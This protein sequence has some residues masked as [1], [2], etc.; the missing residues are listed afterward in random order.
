MNVANLADSEL[1]PADNQPL[2]SGGQRACL[3]SGPRVTW[4]KSL[5]ARTAGVH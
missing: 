2:T 4:D 1:L 5:P 3:F